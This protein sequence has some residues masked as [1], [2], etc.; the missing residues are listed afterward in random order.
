M[1]IDPK[2]RLAGVPIVE[3]RDFLRKHAQH[4]WEPDDL[5]ARFGRERAEE[6]SRQA[7]REGRQFSNFVEHL[8]YAETRVRRFLKARSRVLQF[9]TMDDGIL[10][11]AVTKVI[12]EDLE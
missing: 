2:Q 11:S 8:C 12:F 7:V 9:T 1:N 10:R 6:Q 3:V 4:G 5:H